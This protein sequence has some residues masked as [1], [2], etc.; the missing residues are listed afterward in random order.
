MVSDFAILHFQEVLSFGARDFLESMELRWP[1]KALCF[2]GQDTGLSREDSGGTSDG[3][4]LSVKCTQKKFSKLI[5][6]ET[7]VVP[8]NQDMAQ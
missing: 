3:L 2:S 7:S 5:K 6:N 1:R 4:G 8:G